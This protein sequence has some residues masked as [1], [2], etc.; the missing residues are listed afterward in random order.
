MTATILRKRSEKVVGADLLS[1]WTRGQ[2]VYSKAPSSLYSQKLR[3][4]LGFQKRRWFLWELQRHFSH[5]QSTKCLPAKEL[6]VAIL[7]R[8]LWPY[9][10]VKKGTK[11]FQE[12]SPHESQG[13]K[14]VV[15]YQVSFLI[16]YFHVL[17]VSLGPTS[18]IF[19]LY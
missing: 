4:S 7:L 12:G 3:A 2:L 11:T 10:R 8:N 1:Q 18:S 19:M 15:S 5:C 9:K 14:L 16:R 6:P 17:C 13:F